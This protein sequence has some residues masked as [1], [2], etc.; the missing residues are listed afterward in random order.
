MINEI[1]AVLPQQHWTGL[2]ETWLVQERNKMP[3]LISTKKM[4][5]ILGI[6]TE[7]LRRKVREGIIPAH[8]PT[9]KGGQWRFDE[10]EVLRASK[11][12][13]DYEEGAE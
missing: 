8:R 10:H 11:T 3:E 9:G 13:P 4:A 1:T 2:R 12:R 5:R 7:T 6:S